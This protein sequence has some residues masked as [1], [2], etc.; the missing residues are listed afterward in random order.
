[1]SGK[2]M[3]G[4]RV[5]IGT[6]AIPKK[7]IKMNM[8]IKKT[9]DIK[10]ITISKIISHGAI[11]I[12]ITRKRNGGGC[13]IINRMTT[14]MIREIGITRMSEETASSMTII[15]DLNIRKENTKLMKNKDSILIV[16][17]LVEIAVN[18]LIT[19][20]I[21]VLALTM[22]SSITKDPDTENE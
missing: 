7:V 11:K 9:G 18:T 1:M 12:S 2:V 5:I 6:G 20:M 19:I 13:Q 21:K 17:D 4:V 14:I 3:T 22:I 16:I 8:Y 10:V 15:N